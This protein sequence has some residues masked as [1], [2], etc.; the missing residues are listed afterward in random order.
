MQRAKIHSEDQMIKVVSFDLWNT[1]LSG[2]NSE[3]SENFRCE[4]MREVFLRRGYDIS[5]GR[6]N[7]AIKKA[8]DY[9][10]LEWLNKYYTL[11]TSMAVEVILSELSLNAD[12]VLRKEILLIMQKNLI[13]SDNRVIEGMRELVLELK[14]K[15][16]LA[17][18]SD[19]G[20]TPGRYLREVIKNIGLYDAF[21]IYAFSDEV[22]VSKPHKKIFEYVLNS[23]GAEPEEGVHIGDIPATDIKGANDIGM[24]SVHFYKETYLFKD[25]EKNSP[26]FSTDSPEGILNYIRGL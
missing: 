21:S 9:F 10:N 16:T 15:Y 23:V 2:T 13:Q 14:D 6:I 17:I 24:K 8:W 1:L 18:I 4:K 19:A 26:S 3:A 22:G 11:Q 12:E 20:F 7:D 5:S 25:S